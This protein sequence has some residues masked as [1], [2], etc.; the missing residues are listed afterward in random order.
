MPIEI[1]PHSTGPLFVAD[2]S[3]VRKIVFQPD[4]LALTTAAEHN[5]NYHGLAY[6]KTND[7]L[8]ELIEHLTNNEIK[9]ILLEAHRTLKKNGELLITT[10]NYFSI[11]PFLE[12][13]V[14]KFSKLSYEDQH[15]NKFNKFNI[16]NILKK[17]KFKIICLKS[18]L[19]LS[20]F[21][22]FLSFQISLKFIKLDNFFTKIIPGH[23]LYIKLKKLY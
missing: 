3:E 13:N 2:Q 19:L 5:E 15:I 18:F 9:L 17:K 23:L 10:P 22:A 7:S 14:N 12:L 20:P 6:A 11:W 21:L 1:F 8:I 4:I 16:K